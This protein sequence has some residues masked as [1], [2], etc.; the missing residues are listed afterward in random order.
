LT[1]LGVNLSLS[2]RNG[3]TP[4]INTEPTDQLGTSTPIRTSALSEQSLATTYGISVFSVWPGRQ[5]RQTLRWSA[6]LWSPASYI[7]QF[8]VDAQQRKSTRAVQ[9]AWQMPHG[10]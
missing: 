2:A 4:S 9:F 8:S 3:T 7:A 10:T 1:S 5:D 6:E